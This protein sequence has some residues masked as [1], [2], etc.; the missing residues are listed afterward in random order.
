[1]G[2]VLKVDWIFWILY[3]LVVVAQALVVEVQPL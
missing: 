3:Y 1:L 2:E